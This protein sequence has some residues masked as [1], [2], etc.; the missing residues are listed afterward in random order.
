MS[1]FPKWPLVIVEW[2]DSVSDSSWSFR[3]EDSDAPFPM[4]T[5][6]S[7]GWLAGKTDQA[8]TIYSHIGLHPEN[9]KLQ[10]HSEMIIPAAAV[11]RIRRLGKV[12]PK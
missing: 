2:V 4:S 3:A 9:S 5:I 11:K 1:E 7:V 8:V 6:T 12:W 10:V